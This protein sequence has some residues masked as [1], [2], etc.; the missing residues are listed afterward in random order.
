VESRLRLL[1]AQLISPIRDRTIA[2]YA[3]KGRRQDAPKP[4]T[5]ARKELRKTVTPIAQDLA[6][7]THAQVAQSLGVDPSDM[8]VDLSEQTFGFVDGLVEA[9]EG[10]PVEAT[11]AAASA[12]AEWETVAEE[13]RTVDA[14]ATLLNDAFD[15]AEGKLQNTVRMLFGDTFAQMNQA[16]Q[17]QA[18]VTGYYWKAHHDDRVREAHEA[19]DNMDAEEPYSWDDPPLKAEDSS[20]G[21]DCHPG[22]DYNCRCIAVPAAQTDVS[23]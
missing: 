20:N 9:L 10:Y 11:R 23:E 1:V 13:D 12:F 6:K 17:V 3:H 15:G 16:V 5:L 19:V 22:D 8:P 4:R 14:L 18:G 21:E 2:E 7:N